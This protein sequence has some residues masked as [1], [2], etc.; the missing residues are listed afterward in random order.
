MKFS[1]NWIRQLT[2]NLHVSPQDLG[3]LITTKTAE[4]EGVDAYG[5]HLAHVCVARVLAVEPI[6][7]G[8]NKKVLVET[9]RYG[10]KTVVC[11][12]PNCRPGMVSAYVPP[13]TRLDGREI[14][15]AVIDG[16]ASEGMLASGAELGI[17]RDA[18]GI[19][20]LDGEPG[21]PLPGCEPD[22]VLEIDNKAI[23]HRPDLWGHHGL[24]REV[25]AITGAALREP[26][27]LDLLPEGAAPVRVEIED[28]ELCPRYSALALENVTVGPSPLWLQYRL[29]AVG[30]NPI[31]NVVDV[32]NYV[33]AELAQPMHAFDWD[34]LRGPAICVRP[35]RDGER[36][37][38]L[39][40]QEYRLDQRD[41]VI[42]DARGPIALAGVIGGLDTGIH[43]GTRRIV[44]ESACFQASS[45]RKTSSRHKLRTDASMRFEKAQDPVNTVR[46]LARAL[47]LLRQVCPG[48]RVAGGVADAGRPLPVPPS[49]LLPVEWLCR[50]L[51]RAVEPAEVTR[52]L[53]RLGFG[54]EEA[55]PGALRVTVPSWRAT[56][57]VSIK[58]DLVEEVG[59]MIGYD[60]IAPQAPA[61]VVAPPPPSPERLFHRAVRRTMVELGFTEV[62]NYSFVGE[63]Q[64]RRFGMDPADH[65]RVANPIGTDR[66]LLRRS[67]LPEIFENILENSKHYEH[68]RIFEIGRE[69]HKQPAGLPREIPHMMA[70]IYSRQGVEDGLME[71]KRAAE[72]LMEGCELCPGFSRSYEHPA[73]AGSV[74]WRGTVV[75]RLFELHPSLLEGRAAVLDLDLQ[76][77]LALQEDGKRYR[78]I[79][80]FPASA[81]D[82]SVIA[83]RRELAA[84]LSRQLA[85]LAAPELEAITY[86]RQY[87]GP[88]L[89]EGKKS[90]SFRLTVA[91]PDRTLSS[92]EVG[93]IRARIIEGMRARGYDF[94]L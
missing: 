46:G 29:Q 86:L 27:R 30:L 60:A 3:R 6:G 78:P 88:P 87:S 21:A 43:E 90:V 22:H 64:A 2:E 35:A 11:G 44:L 10:L 69:I 93:A 14:G 40:E 94:R 16:V 61:V 8:R 52:I 75:G 92:E 54:V 9:G 58:D 56:R 32:T 12:A 31:N 59:R 89:P 15:V 24:A 49:I 73:R 72:H 62:Y 85:D 74:V 91:A 79:R 47:E 53:K 36:L 7:S 84:N 45:I 67:L 34:L 82:L 39:N 20:E 18:S 4:C 81:F 83:D 17:N 42:A 70:A 19:L 26:V 50:K 37:L 80:R 57:D 5:E 33:M 65:V 77:M 68:F 1:F 23:T 28:L 41:L 71:L 76:V 25:A 13:G 38:A 63:E 66:T 55:E 51:G 48:I